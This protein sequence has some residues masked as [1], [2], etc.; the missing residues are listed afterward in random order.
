MAGASGNFELNVFKPVII[1]AVLQS[2]RILTGSMISFNRHCAVGIVPRRERVE[3][4]MRRSLML[5]TA[6]T[7]HIGYDRAA[8]IAKYAN[9]QY[10]TLREAALQLEE[11]TAEDFDTYIVP[12]DML[13]PHA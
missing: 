13:S 10:I 5:V 3:E 12:K 4:F 11:V 7:P 9:E 2:I 8:R 6:L 1:D